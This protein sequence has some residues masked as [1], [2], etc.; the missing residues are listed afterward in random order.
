MTTQLTEVLQKVGTDLSQLESM[1]AQY[2]VTDEKSQG[3]CIELLKALKARKNRIDDIRKEFVGPLNDQ[4]K[5]INGMFKPEI[6]RIE[7][8][9]AALRKT[10]K[11]YM[12]KEAKK[13]AIEQE[14]LRKEHEEKERKAREEADRLRK[15]AEAQKDEEKK[16]EMLKEAIDV[17]HKVAEEVAPIVTQKPTVYSGGASATRKLVWK[18]KVNN[19]EELRK[20]RPDLF[21]LNEKLLNELM[22]QGV[23]ELPG[24]EFYQDSQPSIR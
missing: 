14:R 24:V 21:I 15:E 13:A 10:L 12:D 2:V 9:D 5:K 18:W 1:Y 17:E 8:L 3:E 23:R 4:V 22:R 19:E 7:S 20:H 16:Q 11:D 6:L